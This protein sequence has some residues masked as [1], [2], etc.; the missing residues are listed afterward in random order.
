MPQ[1]EFQLAVGFK[2][3]GDINLNR[4]WWGWGDWGKFLRGGKVWEKPREASVTF[5]WAYGPILRIIF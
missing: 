3:E 2:L 4:M 5:S 1:R